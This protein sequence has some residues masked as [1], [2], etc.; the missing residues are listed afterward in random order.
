MYTV[1]D[2]L[3]FHMMMAQ[4]IV[5]VDAEDPTRGFKIA[6]AV[7]VPLMVLAVCTVVLRLYSRLAIKK[8]LAPDDILIMLGTV[9]ASPRFLHRRS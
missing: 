1:P 4:P 2:G 5:H 3:E 6:L 8:N 9:H 7:E